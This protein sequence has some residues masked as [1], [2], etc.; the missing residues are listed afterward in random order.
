MRSIDLSIDRSIYDDLVPMNEMAL[1][2]STFIGSFVGSPRLWTAGTNNSDD[3]KRIESDWSSSTDDFDCISM[4]FCRRFFFVFFVVSAQLRP[5]SGF[6]RQNRFT[7]SFFL[8][9]FCGFFFKEKIS[10]F[11]LAPPDFLNTVAIYA[12][13]INS[14]SIVQI[15]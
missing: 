2:L 1:K 8:G 6:V 11:F 13:D 3:K 10:F 9:H 12:G 7:F 4:A 5:F 14:R 15:D